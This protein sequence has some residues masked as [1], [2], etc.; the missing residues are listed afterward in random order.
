MH[1][2]RAKNQT[3]LYKVRKVLKHSQDYKAKAS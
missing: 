3:E 1:L 2:L